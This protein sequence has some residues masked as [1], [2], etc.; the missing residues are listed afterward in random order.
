M[1]KVSIKLDKRRRLNNGK[2]PLKFKVARKDAAIFIGAGYELK[3]EDWDEK[4]EKVK[5]LPER[6]N[7]N[8]KL[9]KKLLAINEKIEKLQEEG[10][11]R[12]YSNKKLALYLQN[13]ESKNTSIQM[14]LKTQLQELVNLKEKDSTKVV[15]YTTESKLKEFYDYDTLRIDEIDITWLNDFSS[16]LKEQGN[17][18]NSVATRLRNIRTILNFARKKGLL[19]DSV[20]AL[21]SIKEEDTPKRSLTVNELRKLYNAVLSPAYAKHRDIFFLVFFLMGINFVDL[22]S[23]KNIEDGRLKYRRSKTGA[24]YDIKVEPEALAIIEKYKGEESIVDVFDGIKKH[25]YYTASIDKALKKISAKLELPPISVYWAR[26]TF[27]T[28]AYELGV[29]IDVIAD[30]LGHKSGHRVTAIYIRKDQQRIDD[31]N[32]KVIDYVLYDKK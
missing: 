4:N 22:S 13:E 32:R 30:C 8:M 16:K 10:K 19:K 25:N 24:L 29:S 9:A 23:V 18:V 31:A 2:F 26:H 5:N 7:M 6:K 28:I 27:A 15:Y 3:E 20:F 14:L 12:S 17:K 11:L 21:Y 1:I